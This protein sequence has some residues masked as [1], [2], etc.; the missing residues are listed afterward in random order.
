MDFIQY[1]DEIIRLR[2]TYM[3]HEYRIRVDVLFR[4]DFL[5]ENGIL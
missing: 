4:H 1:Q 3:I 2:D 5:N